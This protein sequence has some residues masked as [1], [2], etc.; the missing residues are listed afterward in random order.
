[1]L[2]SSS[3]ESSMPGRRDFDLI[4]KRVDAIRIKCAVVPI[5]NSLNFFTY[6]IKSSATLESE[7]S[8][9]NSF[10]FSINVKRS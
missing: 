7:M 10:L 8:L 6:S 3:A 4:S 2:P 9:I 1:M 5:G